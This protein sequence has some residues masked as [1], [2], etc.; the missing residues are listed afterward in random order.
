MITCTK[1]N[2]PKESLQ[3]HKGGPVCL[4]CVALKRREARLKANRKWLAANPEAARERYWKD[5]EAAREY[6]RKWRE[7][8]PEKSRASQ[9]NHRKNNP[10]SAK[11]SWLKFQYGISLEDFTRK[12]QEQG[13]KC[14][15][16]DCERKLCVDHNHLTGKVRALI[17]DSCN[18][19]LGR[20]KDSASIVQSA[21]DYLKKHS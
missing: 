9:R 4:E 21:A 6:R 5:P 17:C 18:V 16:C 13:G 11:N 14:A 2:Q 15:I 1:C 19:G 12:S 7:A 3:F 10:D 8:N 20:F